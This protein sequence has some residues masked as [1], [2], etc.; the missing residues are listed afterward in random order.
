M[1]SPVATSSQAVDLMDIDL[2]KEWEMFRHL[3]QATSPDRQDRQPTLSPPPEDLPSEDPPSAAQSDPT[4]VDPVQEAAA[5]AVLASVTSSTHVSTAAL[6]SH[7]PAP[8]PPPSQAA[9]LRAMGRIPRL[10]A[11]PASETSTT[12]AFEYEEGMRT[13]DTN[14]RRSQSPLF[15]RESTPEYLRRHGSDYPEPLDLDSLDSSTTQAPPPV[16]DLRS[17]TPPPPATARA[18]PTAPPSRPSTPSNKPQ[19]QHL[20]PAE[21]HQRFR[22][23]SRNNVQALLAACLFNLTQSEDGDQAFHRAQEQL[24]YRPYSKRAGKKVQQARAKKD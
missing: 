17:A 10:S 23:K 2:D 13:P 14:R 15:I 12:P 4:Q 8:A 20:S 1:A 5:L 19:Q 24:R 6:S 3:G 21:Q 18:P 9:Q 11:A 16:V 22:A 7:V